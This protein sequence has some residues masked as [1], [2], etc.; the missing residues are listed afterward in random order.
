VN[1]YPLLDIREALADADRN[2]ADI[3]YY[4]QLPEKLC[5][6]GFVPIIG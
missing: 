6:K 2:L 5:R 4:K 1:T 3:Q